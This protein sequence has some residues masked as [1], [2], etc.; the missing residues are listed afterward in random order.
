MQAG[1]ILFT[2]CNG[3]FPVINIANLKFLYIL[4]VYFVL[5]VNGMY[6]VKLYYYD[7]LY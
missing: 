6:N 7:I 4:F 1:R 2:D 5:Y 3:A